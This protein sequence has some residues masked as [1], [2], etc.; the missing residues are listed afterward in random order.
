MSKRSRLVDTG[1]SKAIERSLFIY[2][3]RPVIAIIIVFFIEVGLLL[4][5]AYFITIDTSSHLYEVKSIVLRY[6]NSFTPFETNATQYDFE[7][8]SSSQVQTIAM[9]SIEILRKIAIQLLIC[10]PVIIV[11]TFIMTNK[12]KTLIEKYKTNCVRNQDWLNSSSTLST[13]ISG[14]VSVVVALVG[15]I[16]LLSPGI[17]GG[18]LIGGLQILLVCII[19]GILIQN[20]RIGVVKKIDNN[21]GEVTVNPEYA[22]PWQGLNMIQYILLILGIS[23]LVL[24]VVLFL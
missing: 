1:D 4:A 16:S 20:E 15:A 23:L 3:Y 19:L 22:A 24:Q 21:A 12:A 13:T 6:P 14:A 5:L 9:K 17:V 10:L 2:C 7:D 18:F 8:L 11:P